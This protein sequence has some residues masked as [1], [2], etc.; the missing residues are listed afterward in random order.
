[1]E[2]QV[3]RL[4]AYCA[5]RSLPV[6]G[7]IS[8]PGVSGAKSLAKRPGGTAVSMEVRIAAPNRFSR[9]WAAH[10][11]LADTS[12]LFEE[13]DEWLRRRL[14]QVRWKEWKKR[15]GRLRHPRE[16][17][18]RVGQFSPWILACGRFS[19][20]WPGPSDLLLAGPS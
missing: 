2:A 6:A 4:T 18:P 7:V 13:L 1:M 9:G 15:K 8:D 14:R 3:E 16:T 20:P 10:F 11:S 17:G 5:T 12:W 19:H